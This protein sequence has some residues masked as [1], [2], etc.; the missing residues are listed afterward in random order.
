MPRTITKTVY[1]FKEMLEAEKNAELSS[2]AVASA[3]QWLQGVQ[4]EDDWYQHSLDW[5]VSALDEIGFENAD[6]NFTGF[7]SQGDGASFSADCDL[8]K[9]T[10]FLGT[11]IPQEDS[12]QATDGKEVFTG[13]VLKLIGGKPPVNAK[14]RRLV[15]LE[16]FTNLYVRRSQSRYSHEM[17]CSVSSDLDD[18]GDYRMK[19]D[20]GFPLPSDKWYWESNHPKVRA[21]WTDFVEYLEQ[22]RLDL[23]RAI[24]KWLEDEHELLNKDETLVELAEANNYSFDSCG[25][26]EIC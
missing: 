17:T 11:D 23:C 16:D 13:Y 12:V 1:T 18:R 7:W 6:I 19:D 2:Q 10:K 14:Y 26:Y 3:R 9:L 22:V 25:N 24:Y 15:L 21:L 4:T 8:E 5:W 20:Q